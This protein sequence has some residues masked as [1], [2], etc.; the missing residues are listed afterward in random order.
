MLIKIRNLNK[1]Y[2]SETKTIT[3]AL[4]D[5]NLDFKENGLNFIVGESGSGKSTLLNV[6]GGID[7]FD[8]GNVII[9][10]HS[11]KD[12]SLKELDYYRNSMIG[13][14]FQELNLLDDFSVR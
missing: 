12:M 6:I 10:S 7:T 2:L 13:F 11:L 8:S 14:V 9:A 5:V 1:S 4:E 3:R